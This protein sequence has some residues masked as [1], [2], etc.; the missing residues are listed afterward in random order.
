VE[1]DA[2]R[3][4]G[5]S[6]VIR[7]YLINLPGF[8]PQEEFARLVHQWFTG[9]YSAFED[10]A[11]KKEIP[12]SDQPARL[13]QAQKMLWAFASQGHKDH[14]SLILEGSACHMALK[15][16]SLERTLALL[17]ALGIQMEMEGSGGWQPARGT[18]LKGVQAGRM[19][20]E[21]P[22]LAVAF[23]S[24][25]Q[26]ILKRDAR[27]KMAFERFLRANPQAVL[28]RE[29]PPLAVSPDSLLILANLPEET[30]AAWRE[31][32]QALRGFTAYR[33]VVEFR[34]IHHGLWVVN[35]TGHGGH[36][37]CG[38]IVQNGAMQTRVILYEKAHFT[39][40]KNLE[41]FHPS[42]QEAFRAAHYYEEFKHQWLFI[43]CR[44]PEEA[45]G[46]FSLIQEVAEVAR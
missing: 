28:A 26:A 40:Q 5:I 33:P 2:G 1:N 31:L 44:Q 30:T 13:V 32:V 45:R 4:V 25:S 24:L 19:T 37:L 15:F 43:N 42:V 38:L 20:F 3:Q 10:A 16:S 36:D 8:L 29:K 7:N 18:L 22:G 34:S 21:N 41:T 12:P 14:A 39:V 46:I 6:Q 11:R 27:E 9:F 23:T 17:A 35:Y